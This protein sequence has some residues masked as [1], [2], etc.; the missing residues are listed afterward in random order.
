MKRIL[1]YVYCANEYADSVPEVFTAI[2][3][4]KLKERIKT[5]SQ[6]VKGAKAYRIEEF[7][8]E[9]AWSGTY[10][11]PSEL[12]DKG[13]DKVIEELEADSERVECNLLEVTSAHFRWSSV[14]KHCGD[15]MLLT[16]KQ[17][18]ISFLDNS[19]TLFLGLE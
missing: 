11:D 2:I 15:D 8:Y 16:T 18:P 19:E 14:P 9:G 6:L 3:S 4:D 1:T 5:L 10:L 13:V 12:D 7:N 17:I